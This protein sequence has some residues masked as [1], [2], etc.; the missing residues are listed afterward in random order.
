MALFVV[1][2][3]VVY[4][5]WP[6]LPVGLPDFKAKQAALAAQAPV[7]NDFFTMPGIPAISAG[8]TTK[9]IAPERSKTLC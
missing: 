4:G 9:S 8:P 1:K 2:T 6:V 7:L 5:I 3:C